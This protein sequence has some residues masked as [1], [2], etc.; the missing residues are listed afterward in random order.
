MS[1]TKAIKAGANWFK[2]LLKKESAGK[3]TLA[4]K[5]NTIK[6]VFPSKSSTAKEEYLKKTHEART[7]SKMEGDLARDKERWDKIN[8]KV[9]HDLS[10]MKGQAKD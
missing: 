4:Y 10:Y 1:K 9:P 5:D 2:N 3:A 7:K 6:K 8:K